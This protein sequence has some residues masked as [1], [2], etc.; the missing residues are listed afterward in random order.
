MEVHGVNAS[1]HGLEHHGIRDVKRA[2]WNLGTAALVE[3]AVARR[4][5][6]LA[7]NGALVA[8]TGKH[9]GRSPLDKFIVQDGPDPAEVWWGPVNHP[10]EPERFETLRDRLLAHLEGRDI[11][12][13]DLFVGADP[14]CR[15]PVRVITELAWNSLFAH[16]LFIRPS[17]AETGRHVPRFTV[18]SAPTFK[19][20]PK[21]D[22]TRS[23]VFILVHFGQGL[24]LIG[25]TSYA[26]EIKKSIFGILNYLLPR[27]GIMSMHCSA[28]V[29]PGGDV[30]LFFGLSGTGK[31]TLSADPGR[32]L[33]GD[34]E[35]GWSDRGVFNFEGGCYA[36]CINLSRDQEPQIWNA[37]RFGAVLE[38]VVLEPTTG[39]LDYASGVL[40][41]NT[42]AAYPVEFI[43]NARI[44][45][46]AGH[47]TNVCFLTCDAFG[48]LP[49][50]GRLTPE[51]AMYHFLAGYTAKVAGTEA[52]M[53]SEPEATFSSCF[54]APFLTLAPIVYA[55]LLGERI[56]K[57]RATCWLVNTGWSGG[58]YGVGKR[59]SL[60]HTRAI[61]RAALDGRL[62][63][64]PS[65][66][67]PIFGVQVPTRCPDVPA[68]ILNPRNT[69]ADKAAYD[70]R[71]RD[72]A[73]QFVK[74]FA[75]FSDVPEAI[76]RAGPSGR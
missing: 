9:T 59:I 56:A 26:G 69:W 22:G 52:G 64:M 42:R 11:F 4:E 39:E 73:A 28:N 21:R 40:T 23:D 32:R 65:V 33:I 10:F 47:A 16:Q 58:P 46:T 36:K 70:A 17:A 3:Q 53:G 38:N 37:I 72:L 24:V 68:E 19:A 15:L 12:V 6:R 25:G 2:F 35:H 57:H 55:N 18:I 63:G 31:T 44:P 66:P 8:T 1:Q 30:A 62:A 75:Q 13:Q 49:P 41:E 76:R 29:G 27:Q 61:L 20:V 50:I 54:G 74:N 60:S 51:Q 7:N 34:D 5:A 45:G 14:Q 43:D 71:A 48:I 67:D